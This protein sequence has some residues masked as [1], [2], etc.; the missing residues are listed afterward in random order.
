[1]LF[2]SLDLA[3]DRSWSPDRN[4]A[5]YRW[6]SSFGSQRRPLGL[7][8]PCSL[9]CGALCVPSATVCAGMACPSS[10]VPHRSE[11]ILA[12]AMM[13]NHGWNKCAFEQSRHL[14]VSS[15]ILPLVS[16]IL[17][18]L[19]IL[20]VLSLDGHSCWVITRAAP[21]Y[22]QIDLV[23]RDDGGG[24]YDRE[25]ANLSPP[26]IEPRILFICS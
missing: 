7:F 21:L 13:I 19:V 4:P 25:K 26:C 12:R 11:A 20:I 24:S 17:F 8:D 15:W 5:L 14:W 18:D 16:R 6:V 10:H 3:L 9:A 1:M 22:K 2:W 23:I